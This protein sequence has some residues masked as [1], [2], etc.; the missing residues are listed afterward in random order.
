MSEYISTYGTPNLFSGFGSVGSYSGFG[1]AAFRMSDAAQKTATAAERLKVQR[2]INE[3]VQLHTQL[4][5]AWYKLAVVHGV[6]TLVPANARHQQEMNNMLKPG[7][8]V[9]NWL[10]GG[11]KGAT[12][13]I[14]MAQ[15]RGTAARQ[16]STLTR[17]NRIAR[18]YLIAVN[19]QLKPL[20]A[21]QVK[22]QLPAAAPPGS[23]AIVPSA[24]P[25]PAP[26]GG[27][28]PIMLYAG[29]GVAV[30]GGLLLLRR[31]KK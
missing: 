21:A 7:S 9:R 29:I 8:K 5:K 11:A 16:I 6:K 2:L 10:D 13:T 18:T 1:D 30:L 19:K 4:R 12:P 3:R 31:K 27:G 23:P 22:T 20:D 15:D 24:V 17:W 28:K 26:A 25:G 14:W